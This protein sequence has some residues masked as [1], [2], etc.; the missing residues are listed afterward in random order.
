MTKY[1]T[2]FIVNPI[3]PMDPQRMLSFDVY[4]TLVPVTNLRLP[5]TSVVPTRMLVDIFFMLMSKMKVKEVKH[6][7][8]LHSLSIMASLLNWIILIVLEY[9]KNIS[10]NVLVHSQCTGSRHNTLEYTVCIIDILSVS[11]V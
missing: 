2:F 5:L 9:W 4:G 7:S 3:E 1:T 10:S 11:Y 6:M 8:E